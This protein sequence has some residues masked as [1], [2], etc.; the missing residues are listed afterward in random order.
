MAAG[1][2]VWLSG[3]GFEQ[4]FRVKSLGIRGLGF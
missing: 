1:N 4:I 2:L 3:D